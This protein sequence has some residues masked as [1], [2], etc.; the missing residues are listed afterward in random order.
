MW[1]ID[2]LAHNR[3]GLQVLHLRICLTVTNIREAT[4]SALPAIVRV[5]VWA[6]Q[7]LVPARRAPGRKRDISIGMLID[8]RRR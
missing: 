3:L 6:P 7:R 4:A 1:P 8:R 2:L 5:R